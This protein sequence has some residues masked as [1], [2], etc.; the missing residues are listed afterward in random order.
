MQDIKRCKITVKL[1]DKTAHALAYIARWEHCTV[2]EL[3]EQY[4]E[5]SLKEMPAPTKRFPTVRVGAD[6]SSARDNCPAAL[7]LPE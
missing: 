7:V 2:E 5:K 1:D 3:V 4:V 6:V